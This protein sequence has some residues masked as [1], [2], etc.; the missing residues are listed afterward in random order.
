MGKRKTRRQRRRI[1]MKAIGK[2]LHAATDLVR[3]L[4]RLLLMVESVLI[5]LALLGLI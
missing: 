2:C 1:T 3:E 4:S 5:M